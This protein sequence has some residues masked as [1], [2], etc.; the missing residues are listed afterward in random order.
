MP[1]VVFWPTNHSVFDSSR[2]QLGINTLP[3]GICILGGAMPVCSA[4][5]IF[6]GHVTSLMTTF[7]VIQTGVSH[8][9]MD[10]IFIPPISQWRFNDDLSVCLL[11]II[12]PHDITQPGTL[13]LALIGVGA[14]S[15]RTKWSSP[16]SPRRFIASATALTVGLR[17]KPSHWI[18][19]STTASCTK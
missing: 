11:S 13:V 15:S 1:L 12:N 4:H 9:I 19:S 17:A 3:I 18:A 2:Y 5:G 8:P 10:Y 16:S 7:C 14:F 6:K